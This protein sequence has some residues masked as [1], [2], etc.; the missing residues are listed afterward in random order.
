MKHN[1]PVENNIFDVE[2]AIVNLSTRSELWSNV[3]AA[4]NVVTADIVV[5]DW[6]LIRI[7]YSKWTR[8]NGDGKNQVQVLA[9][10]FKLNP[11]LNIEKW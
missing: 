4:L 9:W 6:L 2:G 5:N 7:G 11:N 10:L 1:K 8:S 3:H